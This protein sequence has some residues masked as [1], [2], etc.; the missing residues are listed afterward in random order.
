MDHFSRW[1]AAYPIAD[2]KS[3]TL[4][5]CIKQFGNDFGYPLCILSDR[6]QNLL[7]NT[8]SKACK[9]LNI[10]RKHTT[11]FRPQTNGMLERFHY[12][13]KNALSSYPHDDWDLFVSD[14][15]GAYRSTPHTETGI[16]P[17]SI[18]LGREMNLDKNLKF[19]NEVLKYSDDFVT[20]RISKLARP[21]SMSANSI[22]QHSLKISNCMI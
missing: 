6:G 17:A 13:L 5:D 11:S 19:N 7:S 3:E 20:D 21:R 4:L 15:M 8:I 12:T 18:F 22:K 1:P 2:A 10:A 9:K 16:I 14:V